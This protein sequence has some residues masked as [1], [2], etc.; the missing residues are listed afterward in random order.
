MRPL[1]V[2]FGLASGP[3]GRHPGAAAGRAGAAARTSRGAR[4]RLR[5]AGAVG[6]RATAGAH[7]RG[8]GATGRAD[9]ARS[10]LALARAPLARSGPGSALRS[11]A[12]TPERVSLTVTTVRLAS[13]TRCRQPAPGSSSPPSPSWR[14]RSSPRPR[15]ACPPLGTARRPESYPA[16]P[17]ARQDAARR[18]NGA[19][20]AVA[21]APAARGMRRLPCHQPPRGAQGL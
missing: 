5:D 1:G 12:G 19:A 2:L 4:V 14:R 18:G 17:A 7:V 8:C 16:D 13:L 3:A 6:R 11:R 15:A 20:L 9:P 21:S 10:P